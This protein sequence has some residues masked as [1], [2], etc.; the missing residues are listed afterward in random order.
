MIKTSN[1]R[2]CS[3]ETSHVPLMRSCTLRVDTNS[4]ARVRA[5]GIALHS[6]NREKAREAPRFR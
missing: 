4:I 6:W 1:A 5:S 2:S 3:L